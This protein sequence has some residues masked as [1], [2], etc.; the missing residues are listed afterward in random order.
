MKTKINSIPP[1]TRKKR[2]SRT[3]FDDAF[4]RLGTM[5]GFINPKEVKTKMKSPV[6]SK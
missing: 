2:F 5:N 3:S 1:W 6:V 4:S